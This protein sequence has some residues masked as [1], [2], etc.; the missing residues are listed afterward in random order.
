VLVHDDALDASNA[1]L[2]SVP[3]GIF[4]EYHERL[5][6]DQKKRDNAALIALGKEL[7]ATGDFE[8][9]VTSGKNDKAIQSET[10]RAI[11]NKAL[12]TAQGFGTPTVT[13]NG[14]LVNLSDANWLKNAVQQ[15]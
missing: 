13:V 12:R 7:G 8:G 14:K 15:G 6:A 5:F 9:C 3:A 2:C 10:Q 11:N 4:P 1:A